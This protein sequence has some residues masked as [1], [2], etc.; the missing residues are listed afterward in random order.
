MTNINIAMTRK[1]SNGKVGPIPVT[2]SSRDTCPPSCPL[3]NNGCYA[4]AGYY[5]RLHW[6][7][8]TDGER[9]ANYLEFLDSVKSLPD[10]QLWRHNVAGD[11]VGS[12]DRIDKP[13]LYKLVSA[14]KGKKG[15]TY[16]HYPIT[17]R[18]NRE[19][20][21]DAN[22]NGFTVN[23]S[24]NS[25]DDAINVQAAYKLPTVTIVPSNYWEKGNK[26]GNVARCPAEYLDTNCASCKLCA[27]ASRDVIVGFTAHGSQAKQANIIARG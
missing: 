26:R 4:S 2:T 7:K 16:T 6:D 24:C 9:G 5:T 12:N 21:T 8:V 20:V 14:N 22:N 18:R 25:P 23:V 27:S 15:F 13:A 3:I 19:A 17:D 10:G 1:S 11:L